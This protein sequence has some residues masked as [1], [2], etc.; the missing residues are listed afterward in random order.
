MMSRPKRVG[1]TR[2]PAY[3]DSVSADAAPAIPEPGPGPRWLADVGQVALAAL[4]AL[5]LLPI[6][7]SSVREGDVGRT[8]TGVLLTDLV[9]LHLTVFGARRWPIPAYAVAAVTMLVLVLAPDLGGPTADAVGGEYAPIFLPS[10]FCFFALLYAVSAH[11]IRPWPSLALGVGLVGC[12]MTLVRVWEFSLS[13]VA[14]WVFQLMLITAAVG[15]TIAAWALGRFRAV[16][17]AWIGELAERAAADE[18]RRIAREMHDVVAHSLA[19]VVSHAEA[20][21]LV[22]ARDPDRSPEILGTIADSGREALTEM[23]G[24]LGVL[25]DGAPSANMQPEVDELP[26]LVERMRAAGLPVEYDGALPSGGPPTVA[27]T[28][29]RVVQEALTNVARHAGPE[30]SAKVSVEAGGGDCV[31]EVRNDGGRAA[32][33]TPGRGLAGMRERVEAV[34]GELECGP[35][36]HGWRVWARLPLGGRDE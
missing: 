24:L 21:R 12:L 16:R 27:L 11:A 4:L 15:G 13:G 1:E 20:G 29:Y 9:A 28:A 30:A 19:V 3:V 2:I 22:V 34:G 33:A 23:R 14:D 18:R 17:S 36:E 5:I 35:A 25:R 8:W 6:A 7:W 32:P 31:V 10:S 26:A